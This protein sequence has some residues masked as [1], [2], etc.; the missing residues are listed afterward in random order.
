MAYCERCELDDSMCVHGLRR[1]QA[2]AV[3]PASAGPPLAGATVYLLEGTTGRHRY[4]AQAD[5][6]GVRSGQTRK[7]GLKVLTMTKEEAEANGR[8][9][10]QHNDCWG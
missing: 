7:A 4:H 5:C 10:C 1:R 3:A 6:A 9:P 2:A 8:T